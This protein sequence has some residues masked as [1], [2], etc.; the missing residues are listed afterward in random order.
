M[1]NPNKVIEKINK[2]CKHYFPE[3]S[4]CLSLNRI[5]RFVISGDYLSKAINNHNNNREEVNV[6]KWFDDF[7][8]YLD[9]R[10]EKSDASIPNTFISLAVFQGDDTDNVKSQLFR[11]EWDNFDNNDTH[12]QP[13][14]HIYSNHSFEKSFT[15]FIEMLNEGNGF[16]DIINE[17]KS[18]GIDLKRIHFA[19]NGHWD[20]NGSCI[21]KISDENAIVNWFLGL[22]GHIK[23]QLE[24]VK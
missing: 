17:E 10:F 9:I 23:S 13:H 19:M 5:N 6:I 3:S 8:L 4:F 20:T 12:P 24:S 21:H 11:A 16:V 18:K 15:E 7:W 2:T 22:L 1:F 14:W